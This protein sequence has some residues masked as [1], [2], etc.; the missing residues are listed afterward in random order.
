[1]V[2]FLQHQLTNICIKPSADLGE[3]QTQSQLLAKDPPLLNDQGAWLGF[4]AEI[5]TNTTLGNG[6]IF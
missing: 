2:L 5:Y 3:A 1:M 6:V 4:A